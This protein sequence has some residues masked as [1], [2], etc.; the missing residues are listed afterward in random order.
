MRFTILMTIAVCYLTIQFNQCVQ[1]MRPG[2]DGKPL[3]TQPPVTRMITGPP[4][5]RRICRTPQ[6]W[7]EAQRAR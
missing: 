2:S 7:R 4:N 6:Q 1:L 5:A 3:C